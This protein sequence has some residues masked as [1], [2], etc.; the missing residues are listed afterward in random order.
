MV[1][2]DDELDMNKGQDGQD[3]PLMFR[4]RAL[5]RVL[6][7]LLLY[8]RITVRCVLVIFC[9]GNGRATHVLPTESTNVNFAV[10]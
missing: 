2:G 10:G 7:I 5:L 9:S 3:V 8:G 6:D 1:Y 4:V